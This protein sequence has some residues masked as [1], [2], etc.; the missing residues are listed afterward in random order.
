ML[1]ATFTL[2]TQSGQSGDTLS[3]SHPRQLSTNA[4]SDARLERATMRLTG[5]STSRHAWTVGNVLQWQ[6]LTQKQIFLKFTHLHCC[7]IR[8]FC[9]PSSANTMLALLSNIR[10]LA[11]NPKTKYL[12]RMVTPHISQQLMVV[13][14]RTQWQD[15][16]TTPNA[17]FTLPSLRQPCR[18]EP[19]YVRPSTVKVPTPSGLPFRNSPS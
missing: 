3:V 10:A 9:V 13:T 4:D 12:H 11:I 17:A 7:S 15:A 1:A 8:H 19:W 16:K 5:H 14:E 6:T 2:L 18:Q